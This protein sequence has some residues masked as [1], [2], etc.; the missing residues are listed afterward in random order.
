VQRRVSACDDVERSHGNAEA[1]VGP[2]DLGERAQLALKIARNP[3]AYQRC[4]HGTE[5]LLRE[6]VTEQLLRIGSDKTAFRYAACGLGDAVMRGG[7]GHSVQPMGC[8]H[9][10]CPRCGRARGRPMIKRT[11]GWLAGASHGE[12]FTMVLTQRVHKGESLV[13]ARARMVPKE[14]SYLAW[15]KAHGLVSGSLTTHIVWSDRVGG[16]H[17]H[18]HLLLEF[19]PGVW[20]VNK[21]RLLW[22]GVSAEGGRGR[23]PEWS[24][25]GADSSRLVVAAGGPISEL[26]DD[27]GEPDWWTESKGPLAA[28]VQYPVRDMAQGVSA[29]RCGGDRERVRECVAVLLKYARGWKLRRTFGRWRTK[30]PVI[31]ELEPDAD[32]E[33]KKAAAGGS[34]PAGEDQ[35]WKLGTV[36]RIAKQARQGMAG[37]RA[38]FAALELS[39]K[40]NSDFGKRFVAFCR[41]LS[42]APAT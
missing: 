5:T 36:H 7:D 28:A 30:P 33:K 10:L 31:V 24:Q 25:Y 11:L 6:E 15:I 12:I 9:R 29:A 22:H 23:R 2:D 16:W 17:Y 13:D 26:K 32:A 38:V 4:I 42:V 20:S 41:S 14:R 8:G 19:P 39:C 35:R 21:L 27:E 1:S 3:A 37:A 40:N 34:A 18:V